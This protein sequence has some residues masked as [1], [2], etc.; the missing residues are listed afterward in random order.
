MTIQ[1]ENGGM[2]NLEG[3]AIS[4]TRAASMR[5]GKLALHTSD[6]RA[7]SQIISHHLSAFQSKTEH[8]QSLGVPQTLF[9]VRCLLLG[10]Q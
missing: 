1:K 10:I 9:A 6:N 3:D 7:Q 4:V 8:M 5:K 2:C